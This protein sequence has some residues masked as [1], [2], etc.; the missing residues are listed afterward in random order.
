MKTKLIIGSV[1]ILLAGGAIGAWG[2]YSY[3]QKLFVGVASLDEKDF[4]IET[5]PN[6]KALEPKQLIYHDIFFA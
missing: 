4:Y 5:V 2:V 6:S 3:G 1:V